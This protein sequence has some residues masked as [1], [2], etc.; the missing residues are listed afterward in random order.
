M[1]MPGRKVLLETW[2]KGAHCVLCVK[3]DALIPDADPSEPVLEPVTVRLLDELQK[4]VDTG[5][6][7]AILL[8][9]PGAR[10]YVPIAVAHREAI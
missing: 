1:P 7:A 3:V 10:V 9:A 4:L 8:L 2:I 5:D 6:L